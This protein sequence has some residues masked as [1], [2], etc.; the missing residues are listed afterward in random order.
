MKKIIFLVF[1]KEYDYKKGVFMAKS[2]SLGY[3]IHSALA[4]INLQ[5]KEKRTDIFNKENDTNYTVQTRTDRK[6]CSGECKLCP[7]IT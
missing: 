1:F 7:V 2:K 4:E 5:D 6:I 3:Q